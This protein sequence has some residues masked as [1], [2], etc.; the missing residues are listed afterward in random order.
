MTPD[1]SPPSR[2]AKNCFGSGYLGSLR[3][4]SGVFENLNVVIA[5]GDAM[6]D[7]ENDKQSAL[8]DGPNQKGRLT[9]QQ[10][11][12]AAVRVGFQTPKVRPSLHFDE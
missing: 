4:E 12:S 6:N 11:T 7:H 2:H 9:S 1:G 5:G 10:G 8:E 3:A